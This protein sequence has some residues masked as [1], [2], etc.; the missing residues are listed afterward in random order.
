MRP[1][2][3]LCSRLKCTLW[4][5]PRAFDTVVALVGMLRTAS[6][7]S[8]QTGFHIVSPRFGKLFAFALIFLFFRLWEKPVC[9]C[10]PAAR[11]AKCVGQQSRG[12][13]PQAS[14]QEPGHEPESRELGQHVAM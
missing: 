7:V 11:I 13:N 8:L 4:A 10:I 1:A 3:T 14:T 2:A 12:A 6:L 5:G 9:T